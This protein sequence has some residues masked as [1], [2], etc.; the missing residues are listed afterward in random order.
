ME[1]AIEGR[2]PSVEG[3]TLRL[4]VPPTPQHVPSAREHLVEFILGHGVDRADL[5]EFLTAFGEALA[6]AVE[7][8]RAE[9]PIEISCWLVETD[10]LVATV[11]DRGVGFQAKEAT[12][13]ADLPDALAE[14]GRGLPIMRNCTDLFTVETAPGKGTVVIL[15]RY[16]RRPAN[17]RGLARTG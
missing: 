13:R 17:R 8:S 11:V 14:R 16:L 15:G 7:H 3:A 5:V 12:T 2:R 9:A 1:Q 6:N 10:Q 4:H